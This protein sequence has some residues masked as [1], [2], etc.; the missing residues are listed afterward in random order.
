[1]RNGCGLET[2][3][4]RVGTIIRSNNGIICRI[5]CNTNCIVHRLTAGSLYDIS[6]IIGYHLFAQIINIV[7]FYDIM[8]NCFEMSFCRALLS[9]SK[10]L[11][12]TGEKILDPLK[13][14]FHF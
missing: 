8:K 9:L 7:L 14:D 6:Y 3:A 1:M 2:G 5:V 11:L 4:L 13:K 10:I 12:D